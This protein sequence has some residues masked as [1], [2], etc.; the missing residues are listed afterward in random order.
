MSLSPHPT[1]NSPSP[2]WGGTPHS[3]KT[4]G[5]VFKV[6]VILYFKASIH[7]RKNSLRT[8]S[9]CGLVCTPA[10]TTSWTPA[11]LNTSLQV[12][13]EQIS[14]KH[15]RCFDIFSLWL[16]RNT[17][18][19]RRDQGR[20]GV[21]FPQLDPVLSSRERRTAELL[22]PQLQWTCKHP[23]CRAQ[24]VD[25]YHDMCSTPF[26]FSLSI[27]HLLSVDYLPRRL[28]DAVH[29]G[30][31]L[32]AGW[33]CNHWLQPRIWLGLIQPLLHHSPWK[34]VSLS[35]RPVMFSC[36]WIFSEFNFF[37]VPHPQVLSE[38][39]REGA[40][41]PNL[42]LGKFFLWRWE[43]VHRLCLTFIPQ[44]RLQSAKL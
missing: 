21:W 12:R 20:K 22:Q 11:A 39:G 9:W 26:I 32:Q 33:L 2:L 34:T 17:F 27:F 24:Y 6:H 37:I 13:T 16:L 4:S 19:N 5:L 31:L 23:Q 8:W 44:L 35:T 18:C 7:Q 14:F 42:Y 28:G 3:L 15:H 30:R 1:F 10:T 41:Y 38:P 36:V 25:L 40:H 29:V 43:E